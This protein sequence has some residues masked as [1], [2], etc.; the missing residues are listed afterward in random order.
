LFNPDKPPI[1]INRKGYQSK[2]IFINSIT[3]FQKT[4]LSSIETVQKT[5][6]LAALPT[7]HKARI[8]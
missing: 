5:K 6:T 4:A 2:I 8:I 1:F 7:R 3:L